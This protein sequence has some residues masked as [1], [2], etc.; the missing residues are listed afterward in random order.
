MSLLVKKTIMSGTGFIMDSFA[1]TDPDAMGGFFSSSNL[2]PLQ[3]PGGFGPGE[4]IGGYTGEGDSIYWGAFDGPSTTA[5]TNHAPPVINPHLAGGVVGGQV[6]K[7][8]TRFLRT[9]RRRP[10]KVPSIPEV[11]PPISEHPHRF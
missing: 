9:P 6:L 8:P 7:A 1:M 4:Y 10:P 5:P 2:P 3:A 11:L